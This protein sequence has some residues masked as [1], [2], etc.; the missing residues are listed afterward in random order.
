MTEDSSRRRAVR[1]ASIARPVDE[2]DRRGALGHPFDDVETYLTIDD[3]DLSTLEAPPVS[4][5]GALDARLD[6][7]EGAVSTGSDGL[8]TSWLDGV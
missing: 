6:T 4:Q 1:R 7:L 8:V 5:V 2:A 3:G